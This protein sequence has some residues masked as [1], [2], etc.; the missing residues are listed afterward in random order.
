MQISLAIV[1][2]LELEGKRD[3]HAGHE[4]QPD[5]V[6][7]L[8]E[9]GELERP[10]VE[11]VG[12][13]GGEG[14]LDLQEGCERKVSALT[15]E[16]VRGGESGRTRAIEPMRRGTKS[17]RPETTNTRQASASA[18]PSQPARPRRRTAERRT[19]ALDDEGGEAREERTVAG[20]ISL[21]SR[22]GEEEEEGDAPPG[23]RHRRE[24]E[25][26]KVAVLA[27][28]PGLQVL[29]GHERV[30][31]ASQGVRTHVDRVAASESAASA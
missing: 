14:E 23:E 26:G 9:E 4:P 11:A 8:G 22:G 7:V 3:A 5:T 1:D 19:E 17:L 10:L 2:M 6:A 13:A 15:G 28:S 12:E 30:A 31:I 18:R 21:C 20:E 25:G 27:D 16:T 29:R 24:R